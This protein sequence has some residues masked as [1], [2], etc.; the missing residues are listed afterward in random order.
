MKPC[1]CA[2]VRLAWWRVT[3][4]GVIVAGTIAPSTFV[5]YGGDRARYRHCQY[6]EVIYVC[7]TEMLFIVVVLNIYIF[8]VLGITLSTAS[9][10]YLVLKS[11]YLITCTCHSCL[12]A[13]E[14]RFDDW[15]KSPFARWLAYIAP[16]HLTPE[17][18]GAV[19]RARARPTDNDVF[20]YN[21]QWGIKVT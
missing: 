10:M 14:I 19:A 20:N 1:P 7:S 13:C 6:W 16:S 18:P 4:A 3:V 21:P 15:Y 8:P 11:K 5:T 2:G 9:Y 12:V 17:A